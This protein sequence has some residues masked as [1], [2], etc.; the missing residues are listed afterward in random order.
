VVLLLLF[1]DASAS[2][3]GVV[4]SEHTPNDNANSETKSCPQQ[5]NRENKGGRK[6]QSSHHPPRLTKTKP[7]IQSGSAPGS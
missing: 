7:L 6:K 5:Q 4:F 3:A 1:H 2:F